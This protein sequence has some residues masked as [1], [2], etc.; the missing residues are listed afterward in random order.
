M[1]NFFVTPWTVACQ[2]PLSMGFSRQEYWSGKNPISVF[3]PN[4]EISHAL[5]Q[6]IFLTQGLHLGL[7]HCRQIL[8]C[9]DHQGSPQFS[10]VAQLCPTLCDLKDWSTPGFPVHHQF[11]E[12]AQIHVHRVSD[13]IQP[14][15]PL[16]SLSPPAFNLSQHQHLF[17]WVSSSYQGAKVLE[18]QL[19]SKS[20]Q[21][22]F[23][24][25]CD[26]L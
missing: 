3:Y 20:F 8:H 26:F 7:W 22:I 23:M 25:D 13:S 14:S 19:Q 10:S 4:K 2:E 24:T 6:G 18:S 15:R 16:S 21:R 11:L 12:P 9:M 17:Q 1:S 5:L